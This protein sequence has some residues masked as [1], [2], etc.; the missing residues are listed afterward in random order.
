MSGNLLYADDIRKN[1]DLLPTLHLARHKEILT[2]L[3]LIPWWGLD[4]H[5]PDGPRFVAVDGLHHYP[6]TPEQ[7]LACI[8]AVSGK[9]WDDIMAAVWMGRPITSLFTYSKATGDR[10]TVDVHQA[11]IS[12]VHGYTKGDNCYSITPTY[13]Y[14]DDGVPTFDA[15]VVLRY[16]GKYLFFGQREASPDQRRFVG[17]L[18]ALQGRKRQEAS[19]NWQNAHAAGNERAMAYWDL[20]ESDLSRKVTFNDIVYLDRE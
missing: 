7:F 19:R 14:A 11:I 2:V 16:S 15:Y 4:V 5:S 1:P 12:D 13:R 3:S 20:R 6:G 8:G 10:G 18:A 17:K 9:R